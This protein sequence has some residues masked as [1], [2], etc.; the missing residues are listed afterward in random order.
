MSALKGLL[1]RITAPLRSFFNL[2]F[3][4]LA[5]ELA[6]VHRAVDDVQR[7]HGVATDNARADADVVR[8]AARA[9]ELASRR[10]EAR[11]A[12]VEGALA[13]LGALDADE[14]LARNTP[15]DVVGRCLLDVTLDDLGHNT[16]LLLDRGRLLDGISAPSRLEINHG[17]HLS[18]REGGIELVGVNERLF[19][20]PFVFSALHDL[21]VGA[22]VVDIGSVESSVP[23]SLAMEGYEVVALDPRGYR[24]EHPGLTAV[25]DTVAG[26]EGP[27][28]PVDAVTCI[29]AIEHFGIG[30]YDEEGTE[31]RLDLDAMA[32]FRS[33]LAPG[34]RL[35]LTVPFGRASV[36][37]LQRVYDTAGV[38]ELLAGFE[39]D[40]REVYRRIDD[41]TWERLGDDAYAAPWANEDPGVLCL[42]AR[43]A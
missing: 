37:A 30:S 17:V 38:D 4:H 35:V 3:E 16:A 1:V 19:E 41:V 24:Y 8:E 43:P 25:A 23:L 33:W 10:V 6:D 5:E 7:A 28:Q 21:A 40:R 13:R 20:V 14:L 2:R 26:W 22:S 34:G 27:A 11:L 12:D 15:D 9:V 36:D 29:S 42:A 39:V 18:L 32:R 31:R